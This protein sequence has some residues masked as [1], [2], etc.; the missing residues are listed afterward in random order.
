M[1]ERTQM[2]E[3]HAQ[4]QDVFVNFMEAAGLETNV[5]ALVKQAVTS[6]QSSLPHLSAVYY[7]LGGEGWQAKVWSLNLAPAALAPL[8]RG[9]PKDTPT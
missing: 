1:A 3:M 5:L 9:L 8:Q 7:E 6:L 4:A 2:L